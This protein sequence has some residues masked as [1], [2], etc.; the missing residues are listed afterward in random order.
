[1]APKLRAIYEELKPG[2]RENDINAM[3]NKMLYEMGGFS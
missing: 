2:V 1:M 3:S